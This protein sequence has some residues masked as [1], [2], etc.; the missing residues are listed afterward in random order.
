[1][2]RSAQKPFL[3]MNKSLIHGSNTRSRTRNSGKIC[4][5]KGS[6]WLF[7]IE[8]KEG[9]NPWCL[10]LSPKPTSGKSPIQIIPLNSQAASPKSLLL[11]LQKPQLKLHQPPSPQPS[12]KSSSTLH[13]QPKQLLPSPSASSKTIKSG[14]LKLA[15]VRTSSPKKSQLSPRTSQSTNQRVAPPTT[16]LRAQ[17]APF[18][19]TE[20]KRTCPRD[21]VCSALESAGLILP[22]RSQDRCGA[23]SLMR[24]R[25]SRLC[26]ERAMWGKEMVSV[27]MH[28]RR[29]WLRGLW[30]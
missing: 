17:L 14:Q 15:R 22:P 23:A 19:S 28:C 3:L 6:L 24:P 10:Q 8:L 27:I 5:K 21:R 1:M 7:G 11:L 26:G 9:Q 29:S 30:N 2:Q 25:R 13:P 20:G 12:H 18:S 16:T 4:R